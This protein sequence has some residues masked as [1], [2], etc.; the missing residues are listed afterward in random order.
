MNENFTNEQL[1]QLAKYFDGRYVK[2][3]ECDAHVED[4]DRRIRAIEI[5]SAKALEKLNITIGILGTIATTIL[6][7]AVK[8]IFGG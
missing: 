4:T 2:Q 3:S 7:I 6:P 5:N 8:I 1:D